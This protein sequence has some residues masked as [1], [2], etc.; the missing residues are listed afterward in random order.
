M[1]LVAQRSG[2]LVSWV[3]NINTESAMKYA[4]LAACL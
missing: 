2:S 4:A 3:N 1:Y